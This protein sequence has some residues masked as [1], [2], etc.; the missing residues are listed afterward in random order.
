MNNTESR[1]RIERIATTSFPLMIAFSLLI[2][3]VSAAEPS[4][5]EVKMA[6]EIEWRKLNP[7]RGDASP[8]AGTI[9]G[10]QTRDGES[11]FLVKFVDGF[12]SPPH[13]H[14]ITYRGVVIGG[15]L[16]NED[17]DA[18]AM[19]MGVGSYWTQP[20]GE[21]HITSA[22]GA[23]IGYVEIQSGPYLVMPP[24]EA[25]DN[26][27]KPVNVDSTNIVWLNESDSTWIQNAASSSASKNAKMTFLWG[28]PTGEKV[29]GTMLKLPAGFSGVLE[30]DT[31]SFKIIVIKGETKLHSGNEVRTLA[32]GA[33]IGSSGKASHVLTCDAECILYI[34][35]R[36]KYSVSPN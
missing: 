29:N 10:D 8:Q 30:S 4:T 1:T 6:S 19:W 20:A 9:W 12:S 21:V 17:P 35:T 22:R 16:H 5:I 14:N 2:G 23:S 32:P 25:F 15:A 31:A 27:E 11:G 28:D 26:G 7:A 36:G 24:S 18:A 33:Y 13:I 3:P 34:R